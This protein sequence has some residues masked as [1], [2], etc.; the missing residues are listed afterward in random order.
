MNVYNPFADCEA[1]ARALIF[2]FWMQPLE[3]FEDA[4]RM[5][6]RYPAAFI[7]DNYLR[8]VSAHIAA[9]IYHRL[10]FIKFQCITDKV[11]EKLYQIRG[12]TPYMW[13]RPDGDGC[14]FLGNSELE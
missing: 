8:P 14:L 7:T 5:F 9:Y 1:D 4:F 10:L 6:L 12:I 2:G 3:S 11:D 13:H